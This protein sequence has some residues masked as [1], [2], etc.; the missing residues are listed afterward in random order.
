MTAPRLAVAMLL[1]FALSA[2]GEELR[3]EDRL[4]SVW[5]RAA[6]TIE[7]VCAIG[8]DGTYSRGTQYRQLSCMDFYGRIVGMG[9]DHPGA[10]VC[11]ALDPCGWP[12]K[13]GR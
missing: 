6:P 9:L 4:F 1:A 5:K 8:G 10:F 11:W 3:P 12:K 2:H 13:G 7:E